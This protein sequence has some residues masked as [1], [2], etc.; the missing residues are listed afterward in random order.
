[1][2]SRKDVRFAAPLDGL[3]KGRPPGYYY[4]HPLSLLQNIAID[5]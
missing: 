2:A 5:A 1:M 4:R 3:S